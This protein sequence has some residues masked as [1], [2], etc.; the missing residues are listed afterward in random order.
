MERI[1]RLPLYPFVPFGPLLIAGTVLALE[2]FA[3]ARLRRLT[4]LVNELLESQGAEPRSAH[5]P[6]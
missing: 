3:I 6:L 5:A 4:R 1:R 2:A